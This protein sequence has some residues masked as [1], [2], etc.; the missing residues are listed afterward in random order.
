MP[1]V[2]DDD[3]VFQ[4]AIRMVIERGYAGATTKSIAQAAHVSEVTLFRKYGS[5]AELVKK[6]VTAAVEASDFAAAARYTGDV[7]ADLLRVVRAYGDLADRSG[8]FFPVLFSEMPRYPELADLLEI[9]AGAFGTIG[10][11]FA[12]YQK[13]GVL[14]KEHPLHAAAGLLGPIS[15]SNMV[16]LSGAKAPFP[17]LDLTQ[18][19]EHYLAG[20]RV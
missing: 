8:Q 17:R 11:L 3:S 16:R 14:R 4:V 12:R 1:K 13:A 15:I 20:H 19:V 18:H 7:T 10:D 9:P 5:K 2:V 6:A